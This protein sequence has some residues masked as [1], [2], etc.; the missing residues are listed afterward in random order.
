MTEHERVQNLVE[1]RKWAIEKYERLDRV[2]PTAQ[3]THREVAVLLETFVNS[4]DDLIK[5]RVNFA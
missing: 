3:M 1:L 2:Q 4:I 5:D